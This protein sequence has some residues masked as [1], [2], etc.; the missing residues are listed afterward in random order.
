MSGATLI[1]VN[2]PQAVKKWSTALQA[3]VGYKDYFNKFSGKTPESIIQQKTEL[4][5]DAG[6]ELKFDLLLRPRGQGV[7]GDDLVEGKADNLT[8]L[9]DKILIDQYRK[10]INTGGK[11]SRKRTIHNIRE[12][13]RVQLQ[14]FFRDWKEQVRF[15]YLSGA[16][17]IN[18]NDFIVDMNF[19]GFAGN[20]VEAPD[21]DHIM[22]AGSATSKATLTDADKMSRNTIERA[23]VKARM[24]QAKNKKNVNM[25]HVNVDGTK[26]FVLLMNPYQVHDLRNES[27]AAGWMEIQKA[28]STSLG[29]DSPIFKN[30]LGM[31]KGVVLHENENGIRFNDY[32]A[33]AN[34]QAGR[35]LL[36]GRQAGVEANGSTNGYNSVSWNEQPFDAGNQVEITAGVIW[37]F[38]KTR[39][40]GRDFGVMA[41]DTAAADPT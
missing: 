40:G 14:E 12:L 9:Q 38:K 29:K 2:S 25:Q 26:A 34:V 5:K 35:A 20:V 7:E 8:F 22:Y 17:G 4:E 41:V 1:G 13:A 10:P 23:E 28:A 31:I 27:G 18:E 24:L 21:S 32:G 15:C 11:M 3:Q 16:R 19:T 36:L 37:G 30:N 6:D 33:G 39:Y